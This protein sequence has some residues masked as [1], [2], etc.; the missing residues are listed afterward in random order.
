MQNEGEEKL[1][2][3]GA[4]GSTD[5]VGTPN[6]PSNQIFTVANV[7]TVARLVLTIVF[8][9]LFVTGANRYVA[10]VIYGVA[11]STDWMDGQIAR[12]TQTVSWFGKILDPIVDR[13][14]LFTGV[15]GLVARG[16]LPLWIAVFV[17]GRDIY[18]AIG[19]QIV[20]KRYRRRPIDVVYV[21][22][23]TTALLMIGFTDLLLGLPVLRGFGLVDVSWL[24][25]LNS[26]AAPLGMLFIYPGIICSFITACIYTQ[27]GIEAKHVALAGGGTPGDRA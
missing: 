14:L 15:I 13:A 17:V 5:P 26:E 27:R 12:H 16:E 20:R 2:Q 9:V 18:L 8:L 10:L 6:N 21:G 23:A 4:A 11:A 7:I 3:D 1:Q 24:P 25:L 22:K 19:A